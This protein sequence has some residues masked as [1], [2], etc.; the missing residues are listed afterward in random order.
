MRLAFV[1]L[2]ACGSSPKPHL[3]FDGDPAAGDAPSTETTLT[4][5]AGAAIHVDGSWQTCH[6]EHQRV[7]KSEKD[8]R[9][10][11]GPPSE[12][13][14]TCS[15]GC[16][17]DHRGPELIIAHAPG[18]GRLV[19]TAT[20]TRADNH[21]KQSESRIYNVIVPDDIDLL[22]RDA[23]GKIQSCDLPQNGATGTAEVVA[24]ARGHLIEHIAGVLVE[25]KG[26][27]A[28]VFALSSIVDVRAPGIHNVTLTGG[29]LEKRAVINIAPSE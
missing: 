23:N 9:S 19:V 14:V 17:T 3:H 10:C 27:S 15:P 16:T 22:C 1:V 29:G 7:E 26:V 2:A 5:L 28:G 18:P 4:A 6:V 8:V 12:V 11:E 24:H 13:T 21:E 25:G 20:L